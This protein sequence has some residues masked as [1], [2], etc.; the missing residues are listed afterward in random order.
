MRIKPLLHRLLRRL[1]DLSL[2]R[3][4]C[5]IIYLAS[6]TVF[7]GMGGVIYEIS[8]TSASNALRKTPAHI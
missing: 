5:L 3:K 7:L 4:I 1:G 8:T 6:L 2:S